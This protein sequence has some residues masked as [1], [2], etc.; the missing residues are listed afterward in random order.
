MS[1]DLDTPGDEDKQVGAALAQMRRRQGL[2]GA[3]L[4]ALTGMSQP[5]ISR[6]ERGVGVPDPADVAIIARALGADETLTQTLVERA[7]KSHD[8]MTDW[9]PSAVGPAGRQ[10]AIS[11]WESAAEVVRD[12]QPTLVPGLLQTSGYAR[13]ALRSFM[14]LAPL[15]ADELT[16]KALVNAV[17]A[18]IRRQQVLAD[19]AKSFRYV[20]TEGVL[21]NPICPP[22]EML[23]QISHLR[24][25]SA[26]K[27]HVQ[28]RVL[29]DGQ[30]APVPPLHGFA[31]FDDKLIIVD[32]YNTGLISRQRRDV[33]SYLRLFDMFEGR[34]T[35]LEPI[36]AKYQALYVE[37]LRRPSAGPAG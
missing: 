22:A 28:I 5:K 32:L 1:A 6:L 4:A 34:A 33:E 21:R 8:R 13:A 29:A 2:T 9:R 11:D 19:P 37:Q 12:F 35:E 25:V 23:A 31:L 20:I 30:P 18:R 26:E 24:E 27:T 14:Q 7:E 17:A 15:N 16:D 3:R 10:D 36:L